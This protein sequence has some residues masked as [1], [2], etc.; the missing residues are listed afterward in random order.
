MAVNAY[1]KGA[2]TKLSANFRVREFDC[3]GRGCCATTKIDSQLVDYLQKI[4]D[5]FGKSV[6]LSSGYR[7]EKHNGEVANAVSRSRH[8]LG[9]AADIKVSGVAPAEVAKYA[10]AIGVKG[11]GL[12]EGK[13]GNF[14]HIDTRTA[15]SFWYGHAQQKRET[16]GGAA[17]AETCTV[18]LP[19][20]Q[21]GCKGE[22]VKAL[23]AILGCKADGSFGPATDAA[24]KARQK[25]L[26][27]NPDGSCGAKTW[28]A[29]MGV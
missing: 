2:S 13:D 20:L 12:Y 19:V 14:V 16:F 3:H 27:L 4:R 15:K 23:Q 29:L 22:A 24:L 7:C 26:G 8:I 9:M 6:N 10:E 28:A 11:I 17:P 1:K 25:K 21:R 5:H 18:Q